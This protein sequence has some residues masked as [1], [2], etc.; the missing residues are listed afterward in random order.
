MMFCVWTKMKVLVTFTCV[1]AENTICR[2]TMCGQKC[3]FCLRRLLRG[4][5]LIY[6]KGSCVGRNRVLST[7]VV[8][9]VERL[10]CQHQLCGQ[11]SFSAHTYRCMGIYVDAM[12]KCVGR[13]SAD[14]LLPV[15][16]NI[17]K[18]FSHIFFKICQRF[19][20]WTETKI[21]LVHGVLVNK[22]LKNSLLR[23]PSLQLILQNI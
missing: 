9:W 11:K 2:R 5:I 16:K 8:V 21:L 15:Q 19:F 1:L 12:S 14:G 20:A 17:G 7:N 10:F 4:Q 23:D 22:I 6:A 13:S 18:G 3:K